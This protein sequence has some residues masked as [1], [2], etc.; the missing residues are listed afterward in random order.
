MYVGNYYND[1]S[2]YALGCY[3]IIP[4]ATKNPLRAKPPLGVVAEPLCLPLAELFYFSPKF[5]FQETKGNNTR[6][7]GAP[8]MADVGHPEELFDLFCRRQIG[9]AAIGL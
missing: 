2:R 5:K 9:R 3:Y 1:F 8:E 6:A 4:D 7:G